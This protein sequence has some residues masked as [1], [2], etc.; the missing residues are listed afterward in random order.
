MGLLNFKKQPSNDSDENRPDL[1]A[2]PGGKA[3]EPLVTRAERA[4]EQL[5][6]LGS[7]EQTTRLEALEQR[8]SGLDQRLKDAERLTADL[9]A[10]QKRA[11]ELKAA[12]EQIGARVAE[13]TTEIEKVRAGTTA[14]GPKLDAALGL[15]E[16]LDKAAVVQQQLAGMRGQTD[17]FMAEMRDLAGNVARLRT[18]HDDVL[19]AHKHATARLDVIDQRHQ[20]IDTKMENIEQRAASAQQAL[21][22]ALRL[23][24]GLPDAGHQL[25]VLKVT[26]D[27]VTQK[28]AVLEQH[29]D[30]LERVTAQAA[31]I[32]GLRAELDQAARRQEEHS[33]TLNTVEAKL[34]ELHAAHAPVVAR[35]EEISNTQRRLDEAERDAT[36][37]LDKLREEMRTSTER[38]ELEARTLDAVSERIADL[39]GGV[40]NCEQRLSTMDEMA[41]RV[42]DIEGSTRSVAGQVATVIEDVTRIASQAER[43]RAVRDDVGQLD[44]TLKEMRERMERVESA[45]PMVNEVAG[46]LGELRGAHEAVRDGLEQIRVAQEEMTR[47]RDRQAETDAWLGDADQKMAALRGQVVEL[48]RS[49]PG[50]DTL[51]GEVEHLS[52]SLGVV[53]ARAQAVETLHRRVGELE[54]LLDQLASRSETAAQGM[55]AAETRFTELSRQAG[56][57]QRVATTIGTVAAT[58]DGAERRIQTIA[59]TLDGLETRAKDLEALGDRVRVIGSDLDQRQAALDRATEHLA[60]ASEARREAAEAAQQLDELDR[61][62]TAQLSKAEN[63]T[64][65]LAEVAQ[66]LEGRAAAFGDLEQRVTRFE[67]ILSRWE[68]AQVGATRSLE[69]I[70]GRQAMLDAIEGQIRQVSEI[71]EQTAEGV[72]SIAA[73]RREVEETRSFLETTRSQLQNATEGM[74]DFDDRKRQVEELERRLVRAEALAG[75]V[76]SSIETI[77]AQRSLVDQVL[78]RSGTLVFQMK[79]AEA[80]AEALRV[81]CGL[82]TQLRNAMG[83]RREPGGTA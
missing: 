18:V 41:R 6:A 9:T 20:T 27:Q 5:K 10:A 14:L 19:H 72:R 69:Q 23:A 64:N 52:A 81:E 32:V 29:K 54:T 51:R 35:C 44:H 38:F 34:G 71:A 1:R 82:A 39:R 31:N 8:L 43:L 66:E 53:E 65:S 68:V 17:A 30:A 12:S 50:V 79:Q 11:D 15:R 67:A 45:R 74:R 80:L 47:L 48:E 25:A 59:G 28:M 22:A 60:R 56:E 78:E 24:A 61:K 55:D 73:G 36:R 26:A 42:A 3:L 76:R 83:A 7:A 16:Q 57:A 4:L 37:S 46:Q 77:A 21:D 13:A 40:G 33:R 63:R 75:D 49:R 62:M 70:S 58:V 2:V